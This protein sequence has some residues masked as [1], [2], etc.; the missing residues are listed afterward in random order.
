MFNLKGNEV[1]LP[2]QFVDSIKKFNIIKYYQSFPHS[3]D[4]SITSAVT[5]ICPIG[6]TEEFVNYLENDSSGLFKNIDYELPDTIHLEFTPTDNFWTSQNSIWTPIY[7]TETLDHLW[8]LKIIQAD[9]AWDITKG[10]SLQKVA[11]IDYGYDPM[12]PD[13]LTKVNIFDPF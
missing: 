11:I 12:H 1:L 5:F 6:L 9:L 13:L 3:K 8:Y 7:K 4:S 2:Q 10:D